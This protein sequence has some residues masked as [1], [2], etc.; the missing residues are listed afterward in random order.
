MHIGLNTRKIGGQQMPN[1]FMYLSVLLGF[2]LLVSGSYS[3]IKIDNLE[4]TLVK[5]EKSITDFTISLSK[6]EQA[7]SECVLA[8]AIQNKDIEVL[9][10]QNDNAKFELEK[11]KNKPA[12]IK[13]QN[14]VKI[15][16][17]KS[18]EC[19]DTKNVLDAVRNIDFNIL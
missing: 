10:A 4:D 16:E 19:N 14:I 1:L 15:R 7:T 8:T 6:Q 11:W 2:L 3:Y 12:E 13:Y 9:R 18:N 5:K 17:V